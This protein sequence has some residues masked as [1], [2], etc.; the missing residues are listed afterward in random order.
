MT[1]VRILSTSTVAARALTAAVTVASPA[2]EGGLTGWATAGDAGLTSG[3]EGY[4]VGDGGSTSLA[5]PSTA[6]A[7]TTP[8]ICVTSDAP[9]FRMFIKNNG[10]AGHIDGQLAVYLNFTGA[11]GKPQRVKIA[12]LTVKTT[13]WTPSPKISFIQYL[14]TQLK[15]GY[16]NVSFTIKPNDNHGSWQVDDLYVD[17]FFSR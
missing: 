14:S 15:S 11:D 13:S 1:V 5:L 7:A 3:N 6:A 12:A 9:V 8:T 4:N 17:P 2:F 16:A 10:N